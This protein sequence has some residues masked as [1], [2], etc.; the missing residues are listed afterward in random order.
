MEKKN[1][2]PITEQQLKEFS[3]H[4]H[5]DP[6]RQ[7]A[8]QALSKA[9]MAD[10]AFVPTGANAMLHKFSVEIQTLPVTSQKKSG[11]CWLFASLNVLR[12]KIAK[13]KNLE[14]F[15]LS[16]SY[17]AFWD[18]FERANYFL[19]SI[20]ETADKP[21][22]DRVVMHIL[23]T[24]VHDG[25]QWDMFVNLVEKYGVIPKDA[26]GETAQ[27]GNTQGMNRVLNQALKHAAIEIRAMM[28]AGAA[29]E[30]VESY[31]VSVLDK[32]YGFLC[33]CYGE[34]PR[35]FDF[36][37]VDKDKNYHIEQG[38]TAQSFYE[39]YVG[40]ALSQVVSIINAPTEDKPFNRTYTV[41]MLGN[42]VGG[43]DV[44]YL[45]LPMEEFKELLIGELKAGRVVWFGS[46]VGRDGARKEGLWDPDSFNYELLSGMELSI[47][48]EDGLN[49][50]FSA[51]NHAMVI[52]GVNL[53]AD[54]KP[55]RWKIENSW[56]DESGN[57]GYYVCSDAW[58]DKYVYQAVVHKDMLGEKAALL[59]EEPIVLNPWDPMGSLAE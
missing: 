36:E 33:S 25:G 56:G 41:S 20:I 39:K 2:T 54:G 18:K 40:D 29:A 38:Y 35:T 17:A 31:K 8:T 13:E 42:V 9:E 34:P 50:W 48:K 11:R 58:F 37:Y 55:N 44:R 32:A 24:G 19:E 52:T 49:Y 15:E 59:N 21:A 51:M 14:N 10:V 7:L 4:F 22:D 47:S 53:G 12:E 46:D 27:S 26:M 43:K 23:T 30:K 16:Q 1:P 6:A 28:K 57:K 5:A 45:N 3:A